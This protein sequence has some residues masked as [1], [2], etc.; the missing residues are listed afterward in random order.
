MTWKLDDPQNLHCRTDFIHDLAFDL[1]LPDFLVCVKTLLHPATVWTFNENENM[2][3]HDYAV[4]PEDLWVEDIEASERKNHGGYQ[5]PCEGDSGSGHWIQRAND[6]KHV[7]VGIT[8]FGVNCGART[9][10]EKINNIDNMEWI[11]S[12]LDL[13]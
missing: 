7:L 6:A 10:M 3:I 4:E 8:S 2:E 12:H 11:K 1:F 13:N 5:L 9:L